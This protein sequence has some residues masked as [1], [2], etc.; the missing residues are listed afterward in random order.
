MSAEPQVKANAEDPRVTKTEVQSQS[1][2]KKNE[3]VPKEVETKEGSTETLNEINWRKF[4]QEREIERKQ[5]AES[6]RKSAEK[7][8]EVEALKRALEAVVNKPVP[9]P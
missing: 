6:D 9:T 2:T 4:R 1:E 3:A 7:A 5:K 8:A